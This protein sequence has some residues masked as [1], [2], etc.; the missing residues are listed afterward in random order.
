[1][2]ERESHQNAAAPPGQDSAR[3]PPVPDAGG[4]Q[5]RATLDTGMSA[6]ALLPPEP[7]LAAASSRD[8]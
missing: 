3:S 6:M 1:M 5:T 7:R 8:R 2:G 4:A